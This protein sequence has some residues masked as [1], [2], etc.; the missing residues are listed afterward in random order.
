MTLT[1]H[2]TRVSPLPDDGRCVLVL[3]HCDKDECRT[4]NGLEYYGEPVAVNAYSDKLKTTVHPTRIERDEVRLWAALMPDAP[5]PATDIVAAL[6][7]KADEY[8]KGGEPG[9]LGYNCWGWRDIA[10][11]LREVANDIRK[12][13]DQACESTT[14]Q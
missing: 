14:G 1:W 10:R 8:E 5:R 2:D 3:L 4:R 6:E 11:K 13:G 12:Q 7:K 9:P